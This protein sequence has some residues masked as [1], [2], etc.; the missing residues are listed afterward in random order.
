MNTRSK[1]AALTVAAAGAILPIAVASPAQAATSSGCT[2]TPLK[3]IFAGFN[4]SGVKLVNYRISVSC[5]SNRTVS[6]T[7]QRYEEDGFLNPDDFLGST[8]FTTSGVRTLSNVRTLVNTESGNEE[9]YQKVRFRVS[10]GGVTS[11]WTSFQKSSVLSIG[12]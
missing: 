1:I 5:W 8:S 7:Q 3:P 11:P 12:N 9:V 10:S 6:I 2:V 4:S